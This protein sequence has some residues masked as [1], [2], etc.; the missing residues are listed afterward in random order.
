LSDSDPLE[1]NC[2]YCGMGYNKKTKKKEGKEITCLFLLCQ[3]AMLNM[4]SWRKLG[5]AKHCMGIH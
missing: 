2:L 5:Y 1:W 3:L 4:Q